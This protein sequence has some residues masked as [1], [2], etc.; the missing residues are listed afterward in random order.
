MT[1]TGIAK[2]SIHPEASIAALPTSSEDISE[3]EFSIVPESSIAEALDAP[4][5]GRPTSTL[6]PVPLKIYSANGWAPVGAPTTLLAPPSERA[7]QI[8]YAARLEKIGYHMYYGGGGAYLYQPIPKN[9]C[10]TIKTLLLQLEGLPVDDNVWRRHQK[11]YNCFPGTNHLTIQEQLNIFEG[12]TDT[13]K[14]VI[15]RNPYAR[16]AS[17]YC[18]KILSNPAAY[19]IRKIRKSAADLGTVLSD[20]ITF[21]QFVT[22]VSRQSLGEMD[23]HYRPQY[24]EG[25]F[26]MV[27]YDFIGRMEAM[28]HD[29]VYAL[30]RIGAPHSIIARVNERHNVAGSSIKVW[31]A[32]SPEVHRL[33]LATF[34]MDFDALQ[35]P[36]RLLSAA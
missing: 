17:A 28:P 16:L 20:P 8:G 30:E 3:L 29:L 26:A 25:R 18:D 4:D 1:H 13:F 34:G 19:L 6:R 12:R 2:H 35:Y 23:P 15:V 27:K 21:E 24:Y 5:A 32:V 33:F 10:T 36:R 9:A 14:F 7:G 31:E 22:V 11:E